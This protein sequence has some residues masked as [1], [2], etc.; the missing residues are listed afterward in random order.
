[1]AAQSFVTVTGKTSA[2][3][4]WVF[5]GSMDVSVQPAGGVSVTV[6]SPPGSVMNT[7]WV[8]PFAGNV[9]VSVNGAVCPGGRASA[10]SF[11][12]AQSTPTVKVVPGAGAPVTTFVS[13][14]VA[15]WL[16]SVSGG[17]V[18]TLKGMTVTVQLGGAGPAPAALVPKA[19]PAAAVLIANMLA[20]IPR[21]PLALVMVP[22]L[23]A[24]LRT[25]RREARPAP[26]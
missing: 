26:P 19:S 14:K 11:G 6:Q 18:W 24:H 13:S 17:A 9:S 8:P 15:Q 4:T 22:T 16:G 21:T 20:T 7:F 10:I 3:S 25:G 12:A 2:L 23:S 1:G 5:T